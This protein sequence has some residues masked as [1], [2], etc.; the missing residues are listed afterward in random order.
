[1][2]DATTDPYAL[3]REA[4]ARLRDLTGADTHDVAL[5]MGSGWVPAAEMLGETAAEHPVTELPGFHAAAVAGH[6][7][8]F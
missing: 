6:A 2:T 1:M 3:A 5:V 4:A 7:G 8:T